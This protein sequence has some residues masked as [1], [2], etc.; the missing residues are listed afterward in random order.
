[1]DKIKAE[2][3]TS[4]HVDVILLIATVSKLQS[5]FITSKNKG[6]YPLQNGALQDP[7]STKKKKNEK[8]NLKNSV[9]TRL[10]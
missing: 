10:W 5:K 8:K 7:C 6:P 4:Y 9:V 2:V 1:M 3:N